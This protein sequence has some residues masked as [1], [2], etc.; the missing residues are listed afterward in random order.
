MAAA[1]IAAGSRDKLRLGNLDARRDWGH[2]RDYVRAMWMMLQGSAPS[3][4]IIATGVTHSVRDYC[5]LAFARAGLRYTDWVETDPELY[6]PVDPA[7]LVG[8]PTKAKTELGWSAATRFEDLVAE[9][10]DHDCRLEGI[11]A[12]S[13][14]CA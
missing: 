14:T 2:A 4:Y 3:D 7:V 13:K 11:E 1:R 8:N 10:V 9:M 6:R 5:E 12:G